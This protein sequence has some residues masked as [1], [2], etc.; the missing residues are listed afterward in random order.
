METEVN[1]ALNAIRHRKY[2][3]GLSILLK[4]R[5][6][7]KKAVLDFAQQTVRSE[8]KDLKRAR[9]SSF[10]G[11]KTIEGISKFDWE[12][13]FHEI[14]ET[15]PVLL[16]VLTGALTSQQSSHHLGLACKPHN[17]VKPIIGVL[18][19][20]IL[21]QHRPRNLNFFQ[22]LNSVQMWLAGCQ[23]EVRFNIF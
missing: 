8:V 4:A 5:V 3:R 13:Q 17:S 9:N 23:R 18:V 1:K 16:Q 2:Q 7:F 12:N 14:S 21:Y 11:G 6:G 10:Q 15:C 19:S 22:Q 20:Q